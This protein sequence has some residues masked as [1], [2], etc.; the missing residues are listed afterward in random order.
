MKRIIII[1]ILTILGVLS[2][3]NCGEKDLI[4][5]NAD[6]F[7]EEAKLFVEGVTVEEAKSYFD[8]ADYILILDV[9]EPNEYH[10]GYI[11]DAVNLPRGVLEFNISNEK[12]WE[13]KNSY[14]PTKDEVIYV[15]CKKGK[16]AILATYTLQKMG[17]NNVRYIIGG[18][19]KWELTYPNE[20]QFDEVEHGGD[21]EKEEV[22]GC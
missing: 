18:F 7:V 15:Y 21:E 1:G 20:Y 2:V 4:Y 17:Y 14:L 6:V 16:R 9:R 8:T 13:G 19:K 5:D 12:Y 22:G 11:I 10:P 3:T